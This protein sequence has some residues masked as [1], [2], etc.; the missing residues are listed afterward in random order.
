MI[1]CL[2]TVTEFNICNDNN[3]LDECIFKIANKDKEA[4]SELYRK[5]SKSVYSFAL[6]IL[7]NTYDAEDIL[8]DVYISLYN[9]ADK[10]KSSG[11]PMAFIITVTKNLCLMKLRERKKSADIPDEDWE[12][13]LDEKTKVS[14]EDKEV[15][16]KCMTCLKDDE[17]QIV[18]LHAVSGFKHREIADILDMR[19][20]TVLS[21]YNRALKKLKEQLGGEWQ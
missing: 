16:I 18:I 11:K 4:L 15:L 3:Y 8:H 6:T 19:L 2:S 10:Y 9:S 7:K 21:K 17:K 5:T 1:L 13:Y 12:K 14:T 20:S